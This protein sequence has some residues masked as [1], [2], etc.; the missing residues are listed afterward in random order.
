MSCLSNSDTIVSI[1]FQRAPAYMG[2][3][4]AVDNTLDTI[5][6]SNNP[7]FAAGEFVYQ[8]GVQSNHYFAYIS[9]GLKAG[10]TYPVTNNTGNVLSVEAL[11]EDLSSINAGDAVQI[12]PYWTLGTAFPSGNGIVPSASAGTRPTE[13]FI[14]PLEGTNENQAATVDYYFFTNATTQVWRLFGGG[15]TSH[16]DDI[17]V[18]DAYVLVRHNTNLTNG[19]P[20][21]TTTVTTIGFVPMGY[22]RTA[23]YRNGAGPNGRDNYVSLTRP[24]AVSLNDSG[25][26]QSGAFRPSAAAGT[27]VDQLL[28]YDNTAVGQNKA[29]LATYYYFTN[30]TVSAW[31]L[32][33]GGAT[34]RG[35]NQVFTPGYG[36]VV[37]VNTNNL[38]GSPTSA[39]WSN[40]PTYSN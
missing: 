11:P 4:Q 1:P 35:T 19:L 17:L 36:V 6:I 33:G 14:P 3:I 26:Y 30:A 2:L 10:A 8:V 5:T 34:D 7:S 28:I 29:S 25:L 23:V 22:Q 27:E 16:N 21:V 38:P 32:F 24:T 40:V 9:S 37:R 20:F 39:I 15:A 31:R 18:N 13:L 12:I